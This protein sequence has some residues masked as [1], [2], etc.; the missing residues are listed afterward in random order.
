[1]L[2][3]YQMLAGYK[4][5]TALDEGPMA[6]EIKLF[7]RLQKIGGREQQTV[8]VHSDEVLADALRKFFDYHPTLRREFFETS[9]RTPEDDSAATWVTDL[10]RVYVPKQGPYWRILLNGREVSYENG[11]DASLNE[12]D[13][14][15]L[16]PPG[17]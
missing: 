8:R 3:A 17:R 1:M 4:V 15:S 13:V 7:G 12:G 11:F 9:W 14:I 6:V 2:Q 10:E 5:A 16:F